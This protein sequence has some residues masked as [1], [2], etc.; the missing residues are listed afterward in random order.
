MSRKKE[1]ITLSIPPG[2][3]EQLEAIARRLNILWGK[4][5]SVSGLIVAIAQQQF[6]VGERFILNSTEVAALLQAIRLLNDSGYVGEAQTISSLLLERGNLEPL[7]RQSVLQQVSQPSEA[8]RIS[9]DQHI[10]NQQPFHLLYGNAQGEDLAFTV[11]YAEI[12]FEEKG[13]YLNIWCD[14]TE[15]LKEPEFPELQ[16]NRCLRLERIKTIV[17]ENGQWRHEGL[18]SLEV[19]L[20]FQRG[21]VKAYERKPGSINKDISNK[22]IGDVRQ[23]VRQVPN[24]FWLIR[25]V[26]PYG[27]DCIIVS[28]DSVRDRFKQEL[29]DLCHAYDI[30]TE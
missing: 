15:D 10:K 26:R 11:R 14:E 5:P 27:K 6:E 12:S 24:P 25:E 29:R 2:T 8:W 16:N 28:P 19:Y 4:E 20:H 1:T 21:M 13:F 18:D 17:K 9:I 7:M 3:K 30:K 23:V 22:V